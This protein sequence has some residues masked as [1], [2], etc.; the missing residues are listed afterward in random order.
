MNEATKGLVA[1]CVK[2]HVSDPLAELSARVADL[3]RLA[4]RI[5][6]ADAQRFHDASS[7]RRAA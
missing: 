5:E 7:V 2:R 1:S 3:Q 6:A 4:A